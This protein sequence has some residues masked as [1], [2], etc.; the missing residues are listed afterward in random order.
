MTENSLSP[1]D[2]DEKEEEEEALE[3]LA[4]LCW[5]YISDQIV[6][7]DLSF[8]NTDIIICNVSLANIQIK[9]LH[10]HP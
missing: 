8:F 7:Q 9:L 2:D 10:I 6:I 1:D 4:D 3:D 5:K